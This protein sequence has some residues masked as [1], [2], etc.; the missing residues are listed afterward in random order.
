MKT[1]LII[2]ITGNF[3]V[4]M[5]RALKAQN[6]TIKVLMRDAS[7]A[8]DFVV[9]EHIIEGSARDE[10]TVDQASEGVDLIVYA[11]NPK[12][13]RWHEEALQMLEPT[14]KVAELKQLKILFPGNVYNF[15]PQAQSIHEETMMNPPTDKGQIRIAMERRLKEAANKGARVLIVRAGDFLGP[16]MHMS[17]LDFI[18]KRKSQGLTM[19]MPHS[20]QHVHFWSYLPDLCAN[21]GL[22]AEKIDSD[23]EIYHDPGLALT[24]AD[25]VQALQ[26]RGVMVKVKPFPWWFFKAVSPFNPVLREVLKMRYLWQETV[27]LDGSKMRATLGEQ[28]HATPLSSVIEQ[29][30]LVGEADK[31]LKFA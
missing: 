5:A 31:S 25:W 13:H 10:S 1:A 20:D 30:L 12:Y 19:S 22:L 27:V 16:K 28:L 7:K 11:A 8:P 6:W 23:F 21:A 18:A 24:T 9:P 29:V 26:E 15:A 3:G 2:G 14:A 4:E 17:W